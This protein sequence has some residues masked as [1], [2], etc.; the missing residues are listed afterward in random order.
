MPP[1]QANVNP[2]ASPK[3]AAAEPR[4]RAERLFRWRLIPTFFLYVYGFGGVLLALEMAGLLLWLVLFDRE[5]F[6]GPPVKVTTFFATVFLCA[7]VA[8]TAGCLLIAA[9]RLC[10]R[11]GDG[12]WPRAGKL[13]TLGFGLC[14]AWGLVVWLVLN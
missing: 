9:A 13:A 2:Y 4:P 7:V 3:A 10:W 12:D 1:E 8:A 5:R 14:L 11:A 6:V